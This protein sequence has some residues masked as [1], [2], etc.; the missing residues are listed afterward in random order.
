MRHGYLDLVPLAL[1]P[2][3]PGGLCG[4]RT[5]HPTI[6]LL[7]EELEDDS[8]DLPCA[9]RRPVHAAGRGYVRAQLVMHFVV[10]HSL[11]VKSHDAATPP[12]FRPPSH[13]VR[14]PAKMGLRRGSGQRRSSF[15]NHVLPPPG[16]REVLRNGERGA[17]ID[18]PRA[19]GRPFAVA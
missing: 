2:E 1:R 3:R 18:P 9:L 13:Q 12:G 5:L 7:R 14:E 6:G 10:P 15:D 17:Y 4:H 16:T 11:Q 8:V 19:H